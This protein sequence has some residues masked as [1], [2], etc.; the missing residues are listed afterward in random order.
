V[1]ARV[2]ALTQWLQLMLAEIARKREELY[3]ARAEQRTRERESGAA[4]ATGTAAAEGRS[5]EDLP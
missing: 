5:A 3:S 4:P 2:A 1:A